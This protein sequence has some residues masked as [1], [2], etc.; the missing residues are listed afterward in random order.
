M[1]RLRYRVYDTEQAVAD[2]ARYADLLD[3]AWDDIRE[4]QAALSC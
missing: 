1:A 4:I 3:E 2:R